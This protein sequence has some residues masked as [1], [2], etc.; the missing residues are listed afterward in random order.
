MIYAAIVF[1]THDNKLAAV[2]FDRDYS[3]YGPYCMDGWGGKEFEDIGPD[4]CLFAFC[5]FKMDGTS[6]NVHDH[7]RAFLDKSGPRPEC[8]GHIFGRSKVESTTEMESMERIAAC[9]NGKMALQQ[10]ARENFQSMWDA[11]K[12]LG[13]DMNEVARD[14]NVTFNEV[15]AVVVG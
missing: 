7:H 13:Q 5:S 4:E 1:T 15:E 14:L 9:A 12:A 8:F 2:A 3:M 11:A 6:I 10:Y